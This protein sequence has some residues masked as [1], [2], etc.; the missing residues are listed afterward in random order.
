MFAASGAALMSRVRA[1]TSDTE[2]GAALHEF[3]S[4]SHL[5]APQQ[6]FPVFCC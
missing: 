6:F 2:G 4:N 5:D 3:E 1:V